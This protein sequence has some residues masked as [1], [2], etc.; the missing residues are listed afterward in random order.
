[1][2]SISTFLDQVGSSIYQKLFVTDSILFPCIRNRKVTRIDTCGTPD[3]TATFAN[4]V[5]IILSN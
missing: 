2:Y 5:P 4:S 3:V 1:M